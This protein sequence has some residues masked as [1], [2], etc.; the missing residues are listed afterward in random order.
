MQQYLVEDMQQED[1]V[2][3]VQVIPI[4]SDLL[5]YEYRHEITKVIS[6]YGVKNL[7]W[8]WKFFKEET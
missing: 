5:E 6:E 7:S 4:E 1:R 8:I 3:A 2:L